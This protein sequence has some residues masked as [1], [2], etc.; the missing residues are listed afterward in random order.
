MKNSQ[1]ADLSSQLADRMLEVGESM[2]DLSA[3]ITFVDG[4]R[5]EAMVKA[6]A[7][8]LGGDD[9]RAED[10][11]LAYA[12]IW[13]RTYIKMIPAHRRWRVINSITQEAKVAN[14][15]EPA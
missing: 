8:E 2:F 4:S 13:P 5:F 10:L 15:G 7:D 12:R 6:L 3:S 14:S 1:S 9:E 11:L